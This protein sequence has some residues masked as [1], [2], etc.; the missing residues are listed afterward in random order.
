MVYF[1]LRRSC[2]AS[3]LLSIVP[4]RWRLEEIQSPYGSERSTV[5]HKHVPLVCPMPSEREWLQPSLPLRHSVLVERKR[6]RTSAVT[7]DWGLSWKCKVE[8]TPILGFTEWFFRQ[9]CGAV[10]LILCPEPLDMQA[11]SYWFWTTG[12]SSNGHVR[13]QVPEALATEAL[14]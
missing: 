10:C 2:H 1:I 5:S 9:S 3:D 4:M 8:E 11:F 6:N 7:A 14:D 12:T 13:R